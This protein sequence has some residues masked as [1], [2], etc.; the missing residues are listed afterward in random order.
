[1]EVVLAEVVAARTAAAA[2]TVVVDAVVVETALSV[3]TEAVF[4]VGLSCCFSSVNA[5]Q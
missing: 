2:V 1:M 3:V 5:A 4:P